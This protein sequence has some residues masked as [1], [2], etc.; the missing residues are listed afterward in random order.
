M[1]SYYY[2]ILRH[3]DLNHGWTIAKLVPSGCESIAD[4]RRPPRGSRSCPEW[5]WNC[6][7]SSE[8]G[9]PRGPHRLYQESARH[10]RHP[11]DCNF[12]G[13]CHCG[14][15]PYSRS[16]FQKSFNLDSRAHPLDCVHLC[17]LGFKKGASDD[18]R[19]LHLAGRCHIRWV[20]LHRYTCL[21][22]YR[23]IGLDCHHGNLLGDGRSFHR[24]PDHCFISQQRQPYFQHDDGSARSRCL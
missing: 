16:L 6:R 19:E 13:R 7:P 22:P 23:G 11:D 9:C 14:R 15:L 8:K 24:S 5:S 1:L 3:I 2:K 4:S 21:W 20:L 12:C 18:P 17:P 10:R